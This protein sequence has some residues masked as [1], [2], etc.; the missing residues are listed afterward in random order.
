MNNSAFEIKKFD[1]HLNEKINYDSESIDQSS[2]FGQDKKPEKQYLEEN[3]KKDNS[4]DIYMKDL[5]AD[6]ALSPDHEF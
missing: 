5:L 6:E 1:I 2:F 3:S 4:F